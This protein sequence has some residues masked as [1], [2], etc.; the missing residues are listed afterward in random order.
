M[1]VKLYR[2]AICGES[3]I[4]ESKPSRCPFCG[5]HRKYIKDIAKA[6]VDFDVKL[7]E[8][9]KALAERA[10]REEISNTEFYLCAKE[11]N[12]IDEGKLLFKIL[13]KIEAEHASIWRK[14]LKLDKA[15]FADTD[16]AASYTQNL[17]E[18]HER[19]S[20]TIAFYNQAVLE[21]KNKRVRNIFKALVGIETDHLHLSEER[22]K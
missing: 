20:R 10:L 11:H 16:C 17:E 7:D 12:E 19:E 4:G 2:C 1:A 21:C 9:D 6:K 18:S 8:N 22:L 3:Y 5:A 15:E 14:I 13:S